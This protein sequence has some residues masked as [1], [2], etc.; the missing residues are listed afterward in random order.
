LLALEGVGKRYGRGPAVLTD[1]T[2]Q[3]RP[4]GVAAIVGGNGSGKST[5]LRVL[6]GVSRPTTGRRV[7]DATVGYVPDRFPSASRLSAE[8]YLRHMGRIRGLS[9][10]AAGARAGE[11]LDRL[12]LVGAEAGVRTPL[13]ALSKGNAQKVAVAQALL[14]APGALILD[15]PWSGLDASA[16]GV[17]DEILRE[18]AGAGAAVVVTDHREQV[19]GAEVWRLAEGRLTRGGTVPGLDDGRRRRQIP[20]ADDGPTF[21]ELAEKRGWSVTGFGDER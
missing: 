13:R 20:G 19:A 8:A 11:L 3:A 5:L 10:S 4:G 1:V 14:V 7:G 16:H 21:R 2:F 12:D 9:R 18:T 6:A 15:E 17:L